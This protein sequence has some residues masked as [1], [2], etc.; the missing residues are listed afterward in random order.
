M[1]SVHWAGGY[2]TLR[3]MM[4][5]SK[6]KKIRDAD[7]SAAA[8]ITQVYSLKRFYHECFDVNVILIVLEQCYFGK[9]Q[10][11]KD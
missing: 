11:K 2:E 1:K 8:T 9:F 3:Q 5:D 10:G 6:N 4:V 7:Q